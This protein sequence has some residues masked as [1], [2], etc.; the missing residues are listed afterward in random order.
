MSSRAGAAVTFPIT[1]SLSV[2]AEAGYLRS[3]IGAASAHVSLIQDLPKL[4][5]VMPYL[6]VGMG[7][8]EF[9][10]P[11]ETVD[12]RIAAMSR[13]TFTIN[14][15]GGIKVPADDR[16]GIRT[17]ARWFNPAGWQAA[18]HWRVFNGVSIRTGPR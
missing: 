11:V 9:G 3:E 16:W 10:A 8:E 4:G 17:D 18:E 12:G 15:G 1:R 2:E 14:A 6:A 5:P 7:L 13:T